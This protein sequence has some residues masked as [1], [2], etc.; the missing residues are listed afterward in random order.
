[1]A[2]NPNSAHND[3]LL[4]LLHAGELDVIAGHV[5][6]LEVVMQELDEL[7]ADDDQEQES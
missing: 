2:T 3:E 6:T 4:A 7:L 5:F 1:M